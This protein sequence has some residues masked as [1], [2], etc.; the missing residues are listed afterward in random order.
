HTLTFHPDGKHL[1]VGTSPAVLRWDVSTG[2]ETGRY[3]LDEAGRVERHNLLVMHL[4]DDG[5]TALALSQVL[6]GKGQRHGLHAWD[7]ATGKRLLYETCSIGD[8]WTSYSRFSADGRLLAIPGGSI[9]DTATGKEL[10][11][12][13]VE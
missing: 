12:P 13:T 6:D 9:R 7:V 11:H 5:R 4:T 1:L 8:F 10:L 3:S 2:K